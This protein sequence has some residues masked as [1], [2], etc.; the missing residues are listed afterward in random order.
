[1]NQK[2]FKKRLIGAIY[3]IFIE[4]PLRKLCNWKKD[5]EKEYLGYCKNGCVNCYKWNGIC[6]D[7]REGT[8]YKKFRIK[9]YKD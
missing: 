3:G 6:R 5:F 8:P 1:M 4:K 9:K 7:K 2:N